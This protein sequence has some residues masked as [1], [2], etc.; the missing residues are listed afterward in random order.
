MRKQKIAIQ[1]FAGSFHE[2]ATRNYFLEAELELIYCDSFD[3]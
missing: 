2:L 3:L 1:G